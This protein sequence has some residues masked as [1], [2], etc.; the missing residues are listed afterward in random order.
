MLTEAQ[1]TKYRLD[2]MAQL[3]ESTPNGMKLEHLVKGQDVAG[4]RATLTDCQ[5]ELQGLIE[6]GHVRSRGNPVNASTQ[7]YYLTEGGRVALAEAGLA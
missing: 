2:L 6:L 1:R 3:K 5:A 4:W 7:L